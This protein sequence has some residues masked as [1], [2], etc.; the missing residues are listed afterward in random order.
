[1]ESECVQRPS[2]QRQSH[3]F[4]QSNIGLGFPKRLAPPWVK[5]NRLSLKIFMIS[6]SRKR[7][8][9]SL[10][11]IQRNLDSDLSNSSGDSAKLHDHTKS[12]LEANPKIKGRILLAEETIWFVFYNLY[13]FAP[14]AILYLLRRKDFLVDV[15]CGFGRIPFLGREFRLPVSSCRKVWYVGFELMWKKNPELLIHCLIRLK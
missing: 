15:G 1:M 7:T 2:L 8:T 13:S 9:F 14:C 6:D 5:M 10:E 12:G 4:I 3:P 11:A